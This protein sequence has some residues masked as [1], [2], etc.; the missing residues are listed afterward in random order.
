MAKT[1]VD[2]LP[3]VLNARDI[4]DF[5][6]I[7]YAKALRLIRFGGMRYIQIGRVYRI[8]KTNFI[9]WL[10]CEQSMIIDLD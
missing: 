9:D 5:L 4:A 1:F 8:S 10:D 7:G 6:N 2:S 3:D